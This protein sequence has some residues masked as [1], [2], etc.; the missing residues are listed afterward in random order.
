VVDLVELDDDGLCCGAGG[1]YQVTHPREAAD[2]RERKLAAI[3][4][5]GTTW[6]ASANPGCSLH[7]AGAEVTVSHPVEI[8]AAFL[9]DGDGS[10]PARPSSGGDHGR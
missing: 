5:T 8:L 4:G 10:D 7:L 9:D 6:V 2:L 1:A 3:A